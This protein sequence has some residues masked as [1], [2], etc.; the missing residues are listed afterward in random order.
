MKISI[1]GLRA[2]PAKSPGISGIDIR[3][4]QLINHWKIKHSVTVYV[5]NWLYQPGK[6]GAGNRIKIIS[7]F[8]IKNKF[9][10]TFI[11]SLIASIKAAFSSTECI[12]F[13]GTSATLFC[14]IPKLLNKKVVVTLHSPEWK[15]KKWGLIAKLLLQ[16]AEITGFF[17]SNRIIVVDY[18]LSRYLPQRYRWKSIYVPFYS[19]TKK[20]LPPNLIKKKFG[21][22]ADYL[23][24]LGR[25]S[26]EKRIEWLIRYFNKHRPHRLKLV[27]AGDCIHEYEYKKQIVSL[28]KNNPNIIWLGYV[29]GQLKKELIANCLFLI[30]PSELEG[31]PIVINEAISYNKF[32]FIN[33]QFSYIYQPLLK[34]YLFKI[35][36]YRDFENKLSQLLTRRKLPV[37][38]YNPTHLIKKRD[39]YDRYGDL[40]KHL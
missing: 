29:F 2:Y 24:Y 26:P 21:L 17:F 31:A 1:I 5:R 34:K 30:L 28:A 13:E 38:I 27:L 7:V 18:E 40:L 20:N 37:S 9:L 8:T 12:F 16:L 23:L 11:Y 19:E 10:D 33:Q 4:E 36:S 14:F 39:F 3:T 35:K 15:R 25:F 22:A 32:V 6:T